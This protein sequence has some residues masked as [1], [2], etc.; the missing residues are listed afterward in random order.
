VPIVLTV[1]AHE[2]TRTDSSMEV[3]AIGDSRRI[4][5]VDDEIR[6]EDDPTVTC[7]CVHCT[8]GLLSTDIFVMRFPR[9]L[10]LGAV[11]I[12]VRFFETIPVAQL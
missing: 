8:N 2:F 12:H 4:A 3:T 7:I 5:A 6:G 9:S 1:V 11:G 10:V